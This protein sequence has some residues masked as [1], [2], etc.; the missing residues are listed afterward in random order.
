ML[1]SSVLI[2]FFY[3]SN[4]LISMTKISTAIL[5][6]RGESG[7]P[8][9]APGVK[10]NTFSVSPIQYDIGYG[11]VIP[12]LFTLLWDG[13]SVSSLFSPYHEGMLD[14]IQGTSCICRGGQEVFNAGFYLCAALRL[15]ICMG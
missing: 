11:L 13:P 12:S 10:D 2:C 7:Y 8:C 15:L 14:F 1:I 9:L 5:N 3:S 6:R 4:G